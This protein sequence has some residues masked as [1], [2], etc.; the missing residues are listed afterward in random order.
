MDKTGKI[1][2]Y[3]KFLLDTSPS[4]D[5]QLEYVNI[6]LQEREREAVMSFAEYFDGEMDMHESETGKRV[7]DFAKRYAEIHLQQEEAHE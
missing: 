7:K 3:E 4:I 5:E 2:E 1:K 6:L